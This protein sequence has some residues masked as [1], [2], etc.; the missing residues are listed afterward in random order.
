MK[1]LFRRVLP[2]L[3]LALILVL[4]LTACDDSSTT[5]P[6]QQLPPQAPASGPIFANPLGLPAGPGEMP[7]RQVNLSARSRE[8]HSMN[9]D[10]VG[11]LYVPNT[12]LD[13]VVLW[14]PDDFNVFYLRR[15]FFRRWSWE[16]VYFADFRTRWG[17]FS[18]GDI[19]RNI[20]IYGHSME[21]DPDGPLFSQL[22]RWKDENWARNNPYI[23]FSTLEE[24]M[25][26]EIFSVQFTNIWVP[27]NN[28]N[29]T[30]AEFQ[31][32]I[33][34]AKARSLWIYDIDVTIDD[35]IITLST[36]TYT[37]VPTYPN[38]YRF[39]VMARLIDADTPQ[40]NTIGL[41]VNPNP[42]AA[43]QRP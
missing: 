24:D 22:K 38:D 13:D 20:V 35:T 10:T 8:L 19:S 9:S 15:D 42:V 39:V 28:P 41:T 12:S 27:Y 25:V 36:C 4:S 7:V 29:P 1:K 23:Y 11:W 21:D 5:T 34:D 14:Y 6:S 3:L 30:D 2:A 18:R 32:I 37:I 31:A 43:G 33:D 17:G 26:W 16:G 40:R